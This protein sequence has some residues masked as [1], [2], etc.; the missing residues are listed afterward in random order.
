MSFHSSASC[1]S[2]YQSVVPF[3]GCWASADS[4]GSVPCSRI[5]VQV[6][7]GERLEPV[8][9]CG[10]TTGSWFAMEEELYVFEDRKALAN[11]FD[12]I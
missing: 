2:E 11:P 9:L 4:F 8:T 6:V 3:V 7:D 10:E 5:V 1:L 12:H